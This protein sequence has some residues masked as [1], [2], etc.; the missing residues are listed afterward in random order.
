MIIS[1]QR[2]IIEVG[3]MHRHYYKYFDEMNGTVKI[4]LASLKPTRAIENHQENGSSVPPHERANRRDRKCISSH[5]NQS[6]GGRVP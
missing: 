2:R 3:L 5:E 1:S 6:P 4:I